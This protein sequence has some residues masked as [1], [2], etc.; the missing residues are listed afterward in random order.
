MEKVIDLRSDTVTLPTEEMLEAIGQ[1]SLGDD[2]YRDDATVIRLEKMAAELVGKEAALFVPSGT[3]G[4]LVAVMTHTTPGQEIILEE[5]C[6]IYLYEVAGIARLAGVQARPIKGIDGIIPLKEIEGAIRSENIHFPETGLICLE[7]SHNMAGG[8]VVPLE[9]MKEIYELAKSHGIPLHLD[10]AR[11]FNA[12]LYLSVEPREI[13]KYC[14]SLMF[15]LSKGLSAPVGSLLAGTKDFIER[16]RKNRKML[17]GGLRQAGVLAAPGIVALEKYRHWLQKDHDHARV[18]AH[19]LKAIEGIQV[20]VDQIHTN[21]VNA[22][23]YH[24]GCSVASLLKDMYHKGIWANG[25][26]DRMIRF[27]THRGITEQDVLRAVDIIKEILEEKSG[28]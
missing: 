6:H 23:F 19:G 8:T 12:A 1:A 5:S 18:L 9:K 10:G 13:A 2:V 21:I 17:G 16:A 11:I 15:C 22:D 28:E 7:N 26:N 3:M 20:A 27:V 4:N 24:T 14:D 25:R